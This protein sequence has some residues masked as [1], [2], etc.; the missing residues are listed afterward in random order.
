MEAVRWLGAFRKEG[1]LLES[2]LWEIQQNHR[3]VAA[4][5]LAMGRSAIKH[6]LIGLRVAHPETTFSRGWLWDAWTVVWD[7]PEAPTEGLLRPLYPCHERAGKPLKDWHRYAKAMSNKVKGR[8]ADGKEHRWHGEAV[9]NCPL[10]DA[11]V[12]KNGAPKRVRKM[13]EELAKQLKM[14]LI[15]AG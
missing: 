14:P 8:L 5:P 9:F 1:T 11:V 7:G 12:L 3:Q 13:A 2:A 10:Y 15:V 4:E 6:A